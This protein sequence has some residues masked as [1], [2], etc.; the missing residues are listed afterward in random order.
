[1]I[2]VH[3][4]LTPLVVIAAFVS[5]TQSVIIT[6]T[7]AVT[8]PIAGAL[9]GGVGAAAAGTSA[10]GTVAAAVDG[11]VGAAAGTAVAGAGAAAATTGLAT[12]A[13]NLWTVN[14]IASLST[15]G[16]GMGVLTVGAD[17]DGAAVEWD[18]WKPILHETSTA[19]S[20]GRL[21][22]DILNDPVVDDFRVERDAVFLRNRWNE[23]WRIDPLMLPWGQ[24]AAH[25]SQ[26]ESTNFSG[27]HVF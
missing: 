20:R 9:G 15:L 13:Q 14:K 17:L 12:A 25:A 27:Q 8:A 5:E 6:A 16:V 24:I 1:M 2:F 3:M 21:L 10:A 23:S 19:P 11:A 7:G 4:F 22:K 18:C 26:I